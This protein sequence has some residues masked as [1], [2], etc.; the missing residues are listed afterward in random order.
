MRVQTRTHTGYE[1]QL[2]IS[3]DRWKMKHSKLLKHEIRMMKEI[4][5]L[6]KVVRDNGL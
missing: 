5:R 2:Q 3:R 1:V 6:R 4:Q